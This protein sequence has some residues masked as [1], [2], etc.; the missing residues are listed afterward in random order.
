LEKFKFVLDYKIKE[1][2]KQIEPRE[3]DIQSMNQQ[4]TEM[5]EELEGYHKTTS[6]LDLQISDLNLKL[7]AAE[8]EVEKEK[9]NV[10]NAVKT[11][12]RFKIDMHEMIKHVEDPKKLKVQQH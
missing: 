12:K 8:K 11:I 6:E 9:D 7:K 2:K 3:R 1:L 5:D 10:A 4:I